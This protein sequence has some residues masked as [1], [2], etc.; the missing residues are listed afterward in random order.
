M[1]WIVRWSSLSLCNCT[2]AVPFLPPGGRGCTSSP[3]Q[4][5]VDLMSALVPARWGWRCLLRTSCPSPH[6]RAR[7]DAPF[8]F[9]SSVILVF[10]C[11]LPTASPLLLR[12][13]ITGVLWPRATGQ[14][15]HL[16]AAWGPT[17]PRTGRASLSL[18]DTIPLPCRG[19]I[20]HDSCLGLGKTFF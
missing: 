3:R 11:V 5:G 1:S 8:P 4:A 16:R 7:R 17:E 18:P 12:E 14:A 15:W 6:W 20:G 13:L 9:A 19:A 2:Q 10:P